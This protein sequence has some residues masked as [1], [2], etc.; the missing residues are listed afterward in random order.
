MK[1]GVVTMHDAYQ[2]YSDKDLRL[3]LAPLAARIVPEA[4]AQ[5]GLN[6][7]VDYLT[8]L[9]E[10]DTILTELCSLFRQVHKTAD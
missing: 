3:L 7:E 9:G 10:Y 2:N 5:P 4:L 6:D 1:G 8:L